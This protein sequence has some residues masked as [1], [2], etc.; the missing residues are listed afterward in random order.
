MTKGA[1]T[2]ETDTHLDTGPNGKECSDAAY[3]G[4]PESRAAEDAGT[5]E[6]LI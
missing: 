4:M 1:L 6:R 2:A 3:L 5:T